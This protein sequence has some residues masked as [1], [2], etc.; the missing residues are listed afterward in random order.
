MLA[1]SSILCVQ[2]QIYVSSPI[3]LREGKVLMVEMG[4]TGS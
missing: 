4:H 2:G 3:T 1:V